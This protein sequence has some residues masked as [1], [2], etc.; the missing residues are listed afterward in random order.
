MAALD[1]GY[2]EHKIEASL[3]TIWWGL[4]RCEPSNGEVKRLARAL[5]RLVVPDWRGEKFQDWRIYAKIGELLEY[6][7]TSLSGLNR[8][9]GGVIMAKR[10][11]AALRGQYDP[12]CLGP[13]CLN[14]RTRS[15]GTCGKICSARFRNLV[16]TDG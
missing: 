9:K 12:I 16:R 5:V 11:R 13:G 1:L 14:S 10:L 4:E 2:P 7:E 6:C 3:E 8:H 15:D